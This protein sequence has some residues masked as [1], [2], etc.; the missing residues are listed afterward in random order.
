[1]KFKVTLLSDIIINQ[2]AA[3]EGPNQTLDYIPGSNF[4]GIAAAKLY[5]KANSETLYIFH[6]GHVRFGDAHLAEDGI[7]SHK[8]PAA[9]FYPKL[10]KPSEELYISYQTDDRSDEI[11]TKQIKQCREGFYLFSEKEAKPVTIGKA[12]AIK[13]AH[14]I[15]T[16][17]SMDKQMYG[18]ESLT[19]GS[20]MYF[21]VEADDE[22]YAKTIKEALTGEKRVGRSR[23]AQYGLVKIEDIDEY[24]EVCSCCKT[25]EVVIYADSRLVFLDDNGCCTCQPTLEQLG[26]KSGNIAWEK[27]QIRT[28]QY[29]PWNFTRK[30]FDADRYGIEKGSVI[31]VENVQE[32]PNTTTYVGSFKTE[33]FG[34]II[35]NPEFLEA[36]E[37]GEAICKI[38]EK[39]ND[40]EK[41]QCA[42]VTPCDT[43]QPLLYYVKQ[44]CYAERINDR[45]YGHVNEWRNSNWARFKS[46]TFASQWGSI[47]SIASRGGDVKADVDRYLSHGVAE[48]KWNERGRK[49]ALDSFLKEYTDNEECRL[50]IINLA[51][52][53]AK[54]CRKED[55]R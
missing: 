16:R 42:N 8:V 18:Y 30:G 53:M 24:K 34:R 29:A 19:K 17:T 23:T 33:G 26:L 25:G 40:S 51:A 39:T 6:S 13:S 12:F 43:D 14:D 49:K 20:T 45:I 15:K 4:M 46:K 1:M 35:Y 48:Q 38:Q 32:C 41:S 37:N 10:K 55:K 3:S 44:R 22:T 52:E 31:V 11:R 27:S 47:R 54:C 21:D 28:F 7:R 9:M 36:K 2:K 5:K 50:A